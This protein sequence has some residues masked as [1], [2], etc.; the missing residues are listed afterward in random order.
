MKT[1]LGKGIKKVCTQP[2]VFG[3]VQIIR[4]LFCVS[5]KTHHLGVVFQKRTQYAILQY[6]VRG[7]R[8]LTILTLILT[9]TDFL[10][11]SVIAQTLQ[12]AADTALAAM[13]AIFAVNIIRREDSGQPSIG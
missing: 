8:Q 2:R 12:T 10:C 6:A 3:R 4:E 13:I 7:L 9:L 11:Q 1:H 5:V